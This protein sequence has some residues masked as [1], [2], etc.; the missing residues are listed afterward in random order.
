MQSTYITQ[1]IIHVQNVFLTNQINVYTVKETEKY[2]IGYEPKVHTFHYLSY[3]IDKNLINGIEFGRI[4]E[5]KISN[6]VDVNVTKNLKELTEKWEFNV[7]NVVMR[8]TPTKHNNLQPLYGIL[9]KFHYRKTGAGGLDKLEFSIPECPIITN[10]SIIAN[11][12]YK[13]VS[14]Q[15]SSS[16]SHGIQDYLILGKQRGKYIIG[17]HINI[18]NINRSGHRNMY[19][20]PVKIS[21]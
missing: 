13:L 21:L 16:G 10:S 11:I 3:K 14:I 8:I 4:K 6:D 19:I 9:Y 20:Y 15:K 7:K 12:C 2:I 1:P 17:E 18:S 5:I